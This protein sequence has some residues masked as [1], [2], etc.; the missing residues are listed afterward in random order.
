MQLKHIETGTEQHTE[1]A[2]KAVV[3]LGRTTLVVGRNA[4]GKSK[5]LVSIRS[6]AQMIA[7]R[8]RYGDGHFSVSFDDPT[9]PVKY[10]L[11]IEGGV[12][13]S[14][15][16]V[17]GSDK[18]L[19][20]RADGQG[21]IKA[22]AANVDELAFQIP[23]HELAVVAKRDSKQHPFL[24]PLHTWAESLRFYRF[25]DFQKGAFGL[26]L[27]GAGG[28]A[29]PSDYQQSIGLFAAGLKKIGQPFTDA[30]IADMKQIGYLID[31][32]AL[33]EI[34]EVKLDPM[35]GGKPMGLSVKETDLRCRTSQFAMSDGMFRALALIVHAAYAELASVPGCMI[36]DDIGEGLDYERSTALIKLLMERA[37]RSQIQLVMSTNDRFAMNAVPLDVWCGLRRTPDGVETVTKN[38]HPQVFQQFELTGLNNFDFFKTDYFEAI[39]PNG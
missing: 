13:Q 11:Y 28:P 10:E 24:E 36:V 7:N 37:S 26:F 38:S 20:R 33:T 6:L 8:Q 2:W 21:T 19:S 3:D 39:S 9:T 14:E 1:R 31:D 16:L 4:T 34:E 27:Q 12:V 25:N 35:I 22:V 18:V 17:A 15:S 5:V 30:I 32:V 29:D 23:T